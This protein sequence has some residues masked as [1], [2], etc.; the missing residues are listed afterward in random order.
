MTD[1]VC[2]SVVVEIKSY[3]R[4]WT[5]LYCLNSTAYGSPIPHR[6]FYVVDGH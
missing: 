5:H 4:V 2:P 3:N 6:L 1:I